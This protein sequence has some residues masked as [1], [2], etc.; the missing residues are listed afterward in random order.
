MSDRWEK[1]IMLHDWPE[2]GPG[3]ISIE[4][5]YDMFKARL[6]LD[7]HAPEC[8]LKHGGR[9]CTCGLTNRSIREAGK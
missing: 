2:M 9:D 1:E 6:K 4:E 8:Y 7:M 5:L 3:R